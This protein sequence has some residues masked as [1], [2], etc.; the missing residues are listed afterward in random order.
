MLNLASLSITQ[1]LSSILL[2]LLPILIWLNIFFKKD[3][4]TQVT[5]LKVLLFGVFSVI[6]L[7]AIQYVWFFNPQFDVY[8]I[9]EH[10]TSNVHLGYLL[11]FIAI[12]VFEEFAKFNMLRHLKWAKV[13]ITSI[14]DAMRYIFVIALGFAFTE[15]IFYFYS[16]SSTGQFADLF[17]A[18]TFRSTFTAAA[19]MVFSG[20]VGYYYAIGKFGN[21]VLELERWTGKT[22][23]FATL[24]QEKLGLKK[25]NIFHIQQT[26]KGLFFAMALHAAFNF[27]LQLNK[28]LFAALI[29]AAGFALVIFLSKKRTTYLVFTEEEKARPS[30]I[31]KAE[32]NV[33]IEL[34]GMWLNEGKFQEV[35]EICDRLGKRDPD[36]MVVKLFRA[37]AIDR[38]K[39]ARVK[40]AIHLLFSE[41]EYDM[42]EEEMSV[43]ERLK[44]KQEKEK[45]F[46]NREF[47]NLSK[48]DVTE[49]LQD[50]AKEEIL[51][52]AKEK[53][54]E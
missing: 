29:V 27:C 23:V 7:L 15:N 25:K 53:D 51:K 2:A 35:I 38:K 14:N 10:S 48:G 5:L 4:E 19:H 22:H 43:F 20:I 47:N 52:N 50:K 21:P 36:N 49:V 40:R 41:E 32:E 45:Q 46:K 1:L 16:I 3:K 34:M 17:A 18:F 9:L 8:S 26:A 33:V 31:G 6:P 28:I 12:G 37:K 13:R 54:E 30:T 39:I 24:L 11:T 44:S 42:A